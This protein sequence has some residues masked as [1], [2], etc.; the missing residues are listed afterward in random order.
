MRNV[1]R[2]YLFFVAPIAV[3]GSACAS[4]ARVAGDACELTAADSV[5]L[6]AGAV[7]RECGVDHPAR[8]VQDARVEFRPTATPPRSECFTADVEFVVGPTG[9]PEAATARVL[10]ASHQAFGDAVLAAVP[11]WR[12]TPA[13]VD[14]MA[15]RQIVRE[16][17]TQAVRVV[18][19]VVSGGAGGP[20][21]PASTP[22][23]PACR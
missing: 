6:A 8:L 18:T 4:S 10:R 23:G 17:R 12:Y 20:P 11:A 13:S 1:V 2:W 3:L 21:P 22:R 19:T 16:R 9:R 15:V 5:Y 7:H 14:G